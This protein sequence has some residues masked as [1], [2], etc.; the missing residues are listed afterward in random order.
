MEMV[1]SQRQFAATV[2]ILVAVLFSILTGCAK[3][4]EG[5]DEG[6]IGPGP[7]S[8]EVIR[9]ALES[10]KGDA[11]RECRLSEVKPILV[12]GAP[13]MTDPRVLWVRGGGWESDETLRNFS[14]FNQS[15]RPIVVILSAAPINGTQDV[16]YYL[17]YYR[18]RMTGTFQAIRTQNA[19]EANN[20]NYAEQVRNAGAIV[21]TGGYPDQLRHIPGTALG[22]A[23]REAHA[24]GIPIYT[25]SASVSMIGNYFAW[26]VPKTLSGQ[27]AGLNTVPAVFLSHLNEASKFGSDF[28]QDLWMVVPSR[29]KLGFGVMAQTI[30]YLRG[31]KLKVYGESPVRNRVYVYDARYGATQNCVRWFMVPGESFDLRAGTLYPGP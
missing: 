17:N 11:N 21:I 5:E 1:G 27:N 16:N 25:N 28:L 14:G 3:K 19:S 10:V 20:E 30:A 22:N 31:L 12:T 6:D 7:A 9:A 18:Q 2:T 24:A 15:G 4:V 29:R 13:E 8:P 23:I 26:N